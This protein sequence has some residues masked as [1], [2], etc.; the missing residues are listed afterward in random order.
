MSITDIIDFKVHL[1]Y[2]RRLFSLLIH[3]NNHNNQEYDLK[4]IQKS[5]TKNTKK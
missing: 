1:F 2:F 3:Y 5:F 4:N